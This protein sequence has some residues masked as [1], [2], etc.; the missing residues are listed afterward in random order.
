MEGILSLPTWKELLMIAIALA[1]VAVAI[2]KKYEPLLLVPIGI[3]ILLV[4][5]PYSP[6]KESGSLLEFLFRY[7]I[8]TEFFPLLI[9]ISIGAMMDFR[10][11]IERPWL[12]AF[13]AIA[14]MG[15]FATMIVA[16]LLGFNLFQSASIGV[17]GSADGPTSIYVTAKLAP[18]LIGSVSLAAYSYMALVPIIQP[19]I[20]RLLTTKRE[21]KVRMEIGSVSVNPSLLKIFPYTILL[22]SAILSPMSI[23]LIGF[24]M[25]G[26]I[27][28]T[29][30]VTES[31]AKAARDVLSGVVTL[32]LGIAIGSSMVAE[33]FLKVETLLIFLLGLI[34]FALG[35]AFGVLLGKLLFALGLKVNPLVGAAGLSSFPMSARIVH[36]MGQKEDK[37]NYLLMFAASANVSGQIGSV[38]AGGALLDL[39]SRYGNV[40]SLKVGL[41]IL[42]L[43]MA[44]VLG[45]LLLIGLLIYLLRKIL[46]MKESQGI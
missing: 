34:A 43:G 8:K 14:Q 19:P 37:Q 41:E 13:G 29:S 39:V 32:F 30:G 25:F 36:Q 16:L 3:G 20:M 11:L 9:F 23:P 1:L 12:I 27:L 38:L 28:Q 6:L 26:N 40:S 18:E 42:L 45:A 46:P 15:I 31:L 33:A 2:V 22:L 4:N 35:T 21:R 7:G 44:K 17:I 5:L 10:P 24:L